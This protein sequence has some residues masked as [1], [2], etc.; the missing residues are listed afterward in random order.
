MA[1]ILNPD[2]KFA[3]AWL[4]DLRK[5]LRPK[6]GEP[7]QQLRLSQFFTLHE[8]GERWD[9]RAGRY[10]HALAILAVEND[11]PITSKTGLAASLI[12]LALPDMKTATVSVWARL[13]NAIWNGELDIRDIQQAGMHEALATLGEKPRARTAL[14]AGRRDRDLYRGARL[15]YATYL[16]K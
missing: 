16:E 15:T 2:V 9:R 6:A 12:T 5:G 3:K 11:V 14:P 13:M 8:A 7:A 4:A 1:T 10:E